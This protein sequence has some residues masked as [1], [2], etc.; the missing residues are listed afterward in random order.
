MYRS[1]T[2]T[3][4]GLV[5]VSERR[6]TNIFGDLVQTFFFY[7]YY[8]TTI[9]FC[10]RPYWQKWRWILLWFCW[11]W[12][13]EA[14]MYPFLLFQFFF[15]DLILTL[16]KILEYAQ[17]NRP[18]PANTLIPLMQLTPRIPEKFLPLKNGIITQKKERKR[19]K[20]KQ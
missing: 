10:L 1:S 8:F 14:R 12:L 4:C 19:P 15:T 11:I 5:S 16:L 20:N 7:Y 2:S 18:W 13:G 3:Q 9:N 6:K 17:Q